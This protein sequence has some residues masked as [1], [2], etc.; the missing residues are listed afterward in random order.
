MVH[1]LDL[2]ELRAVVE[3][4]QLQYY[5]DAV[6]KRDLKVLYEDLRR[7]GPGLTTVLGDVLVRSQVSKFKKLRF[8]THENLGYGE[9]FLPEDEMHTRF[10]ALVFEASSSA[11]Q[12]FAGLDPELQGPLMAR[13]G[14]LLQAVAPAF[15]LCQNSDFGVS[16]RLRDPH[17]GCPVLYFFD[18]CPGGAGLAEALIPKL[19]NIL[20]AAQERVNTCDC[21]EGCPSCVGPRNPEEEIGLDPKKGARQFLNMWLGVREIP[22]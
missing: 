11:G 22:G 4:S 9:I 7:P 19:N 8:H 17:F 5:T 21:R 14:A 1:E 6:V 20:L 18:R 16:E 15:L 12:A 13:L 10:A 2:E 3:E